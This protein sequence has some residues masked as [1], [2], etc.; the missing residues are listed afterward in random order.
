MLTS[1]DQLTEAEECEDECFLPNG[2][3]CML[4]QMNERRVVVRRS[5]NLQLYDVPSVMTITFSLCVR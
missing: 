3:E 1:P 4:K 5:D 2:R